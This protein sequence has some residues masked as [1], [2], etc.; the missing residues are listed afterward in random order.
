M[1][2]DFFIPLA[3]HLIGFVMQWLICQF[4]E[5]LYTLSE[6]KYTIKDSFII[7]FFVSYLDYV[8]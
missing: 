6:I 1:K 8:Q 4:H 7:F 3:S 2:Q 5:N